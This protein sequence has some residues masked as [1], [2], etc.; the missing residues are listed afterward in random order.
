MNKVSVIIPTIGESFLKQTINCILEGTVVPDEILIVIPH[1]YNEKLKNIKFDQRVKILFSEKAS[2]VY[3][4]ILGFNNASFD[5]VLQLDADILLDNNCIEELISAIKA[6]DDICV[7]PRYKSDRNYKLT[8]IKKF[9]FKKFIER[10]KNFAYWD[11]WFSR[12]Y[13]N[14]NDKLLKT[15]W[16]AGGC[17][18]HRKKNLILEN[19]YNY[20]G[21]A[22]DEDLIH[23]FI[24]SKKKIDLFVTKSYLANSINPETYEHKNLNGLINYIKR[25]FIIKKKLANDSDGKLV[26][27]VFW[28]FI[29]VIA[30][31]QRFFKIK[32][33][34][35]LRVLHFL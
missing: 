11:T 20:E 10:E 23:S 14:F 19:Y 16:L 25:I 8:F 7:S 2:Q 3:Q 6:R 31:F 30:E 1:E 4:R 28:Y 12:N 33:F 32:I 35:Q 15:K 22:Y 13:F 34:Q 17:I 26:Y 27:F 5:L 9:F 29:W 18:L 21:K 24:L